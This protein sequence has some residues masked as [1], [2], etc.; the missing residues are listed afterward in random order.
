MNTT[1]LIIAVVVLAVLLVCTFV[2]ALMSLSRAKSSSDKMEAYF[3]SYSEVMANSQRAI[4]E[5]QAYRL[6]ALEESMGRLRNDNTAQLDTIRQAMEVRLEAVT[7]GIGEMTSVASSVG[8]L[9]KI[10]SNVKTRGIL[11]EVQLSAILEQIMNKEQYDTDV[12]TIKG[13]S[14]RVEFA[15]KLPGDG[16]ECVYLPI[17]SKFP[18]DAYGA[19]MDAY[20]AGDKEQVD[21]CRKMLFNVMKAEARDI[22][23]KYIEPP[24]TT[25]FGVMFLPFEGLYAEA[26]NGGM[27]EIL[28]R[29]YKVTIAGPTTMAALLNS[30]QMGFNTL[31]IE[32]KSS[33]VWELLGAVRTEFEKYDAALANAEK[34][35]ALAAKDIDELRGAR[36]KKINVKLRQVTA[37][38]EEDT[39]RLLED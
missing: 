33:E 5:N 39:R 35:I 4:S 22:K 12:A 1:Y 28:Q 18:G 20:E 10:L 32:K 11:G 15:I 25:D 26:V 9:K 37:L 36:T 6:K 3:K 31:A 38:D 23:E 19:L 13:S 24:Y 2:V 29:Q 30:L 27:I 14:N 21:R 16:D 34:H 8:D 7:R 17:D